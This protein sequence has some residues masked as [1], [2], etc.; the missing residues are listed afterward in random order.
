MY[1]PSVRAERKT[2]SGS[3][4]ASSTI[5]AAEEAKHYFQPLD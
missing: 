3:R 1:R 2:G 5:S 4:S